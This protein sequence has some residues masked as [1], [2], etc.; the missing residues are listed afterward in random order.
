MSALFL[1]IGLA[2]NPVIGHGYPGARSYLLQIGG[3][4]DSDGEERGRRCVVLGMFL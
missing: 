2:L 3:D 4:M 1:L